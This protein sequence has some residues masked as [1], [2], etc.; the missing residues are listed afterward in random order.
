M[1]HCKLNHRQGIQVG[2]HHHI[3]H[4]AVHEHL[5]RVEA[6]DFVGGYSAVRAANPQVFGRLLLGQ[7]L[8][9]ARP[10]FGH[11]VCPVAVVGKKT[12]QGVRHRQ[13][14][15]FGNSNL[16]GA[17]AFGIVFVQQCLGFAFVLFDFIQIGLNFF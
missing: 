4:I 10:L 8:K 14:Y 3:G 16:G 15:S 11:A 12:V 17:F 13:G 6:D 7:F 5:A 2:G 1:L 9:K